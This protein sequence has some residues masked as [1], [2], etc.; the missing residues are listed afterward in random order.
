LIERRREAKSPS[1]NAAEASIRER[2]SR[3][4]ADHPAR[5][6]LVPIWHLFVPTLEQR[7]FRKCLI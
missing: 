7:H 4:E 2:F 3:A 6:E 5:F 1:K